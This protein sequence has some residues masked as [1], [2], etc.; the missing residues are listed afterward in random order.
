[1]ALPTSWRGSRRRLGG[2]VRQASGQLMAPNVEVQNPTKARRTLAL[3]VGLVVAVLAFALGSHASANP[4]SQIARE[5]AQMAAQDTGFQSRQLD[6]VSESSVYYAVVRDQAGLV[7]DLVADGFQIIQSHTSSD[8]S[9]LLEGQCPLGSLVLQR[10]DWIVFGGRLYTVD[11][12]I[13]A[14]CSVSSLRI[15]VTPPDVLFG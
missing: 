13:S 14:D 1:M 2:R 3:V 5:L 11:L 10:T 12:G 4:R 9:G 6:F 8:F 7:S 15:S